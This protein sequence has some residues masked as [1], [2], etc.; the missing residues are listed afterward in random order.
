MTDDRHFIDKGGIV[1]SDLSVNP[2][3]TFVIISYFWGSQNKNKNSP[4]GKT[5]GQQL[6]DLIESCK[7]VGCNYYIVEYPAFTQKGMYQRAINLKGYFIMHCLQTLN[8]PKVIYIDSDLILYKYPAL[9]DVDADLFCINYMEHDSNCYNPMEVWLPGGIMG[10]ANTPV[11]MH[12]LELFYDQMLKKPKLAEDKVL[13]GM[14]TEGM[15]T[16]YLRCVFVPYTYLYFFQNH[17]YDQILKTYTFVAT[18]KDEFKDNEYKKK[19]VVMVHTDFETAMLDAL[20]EERDIEGDRIPKNFYKIMGQK[21][22]CYN[23]KFDVYSDFELTK[24]QAS[25]YAIEWKE[26]ETEKVIQVMKVPKRSEFS[27]SKYD[28]T[29]HL[30]DK[31][32]DEMLVVFDTYDSRTRSFLHSCKKKGK[33][34]LVIHNDKKDVNLPICFY[35]LMKT[36]DKS[37]VF[38]TIGNRIPKFDHFYDIVCFNRN[39]SFKQSK[40]FDPRILSTM[41]MDF[42]YIHNNPLMRKFLL[43]WSKYNVKECIKNDIQ[44]KSL[45]YAFNISL[46]LN[47]LRCYWL[48]NPVSDVENN[49]Y[50]KLKVY[51]T[52]E[53]RMRQ[54]G[55][56]LPIPG[57]SY[58]NSRYAS[59]SKGQPFVRKYKRTF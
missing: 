41:N 23:V 40:C 30:Y 55:I 49:K 35:D 54:C 27:K 36:Y 20:W 34:V 25:H 7:K 51:K 43:I 50:Y 26:K 1:R 32:N 39:N 33:N 2:D 46:M 9:F 29:M 52:L 38:H 31:Y 4:Y 37:I 6:D 53:S 10:F 24:Q 13:S 15:L 3:S 12:V 45:E 18:D 5:Y 47:K 42:L 21:L 44:H 59:G 14:L 8:V 19:D 16:Q 11:S 17:V 48:K 28:T 57:M 58:A 22:R 56:K